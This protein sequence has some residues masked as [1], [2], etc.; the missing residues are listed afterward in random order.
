MFSPEHV[1]SGDGR[2]VM[3]PTQAEMLEYADNR[4]N[5]NVR[6]RCGRYLPPPRKAGTAN[7]S[8]LKK[9]IMDPYLMDKAGPVFPN[10][11]SYAE[12]ETANF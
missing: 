6:T 10:G 5:V 7:E 1:E 2:E 3:W 9:K 4:E 8:F 11:P 12:R